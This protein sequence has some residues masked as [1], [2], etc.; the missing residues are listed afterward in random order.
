MSGYRR[1]YDRARVLFA[2]LSIKLF[3]KKFYPF[4][5]NLVINSRCNLKCAYCFGKYYD[6]KS[7]DLSF[8]SF[9]KIVDTL[10]AKKTIYILM[11]GGETLL[12]QE[13]GKMIQYLY[14]NKIVSA[15]V[16]N[17]QLPEKIKEL[18]ELELLDNVCF[19][20]DGNREGHDKIRGRGSFD[21][22]LKSIEEVKKYYSTP[23]RIL[24]SAHRFVANDIDFMVKFARDNNLEWSVNFM[25]CGNERI[26]GERIDFTDDEAKTYIKKAIE[27][28]KQKYPIFVTEKIFNYCLNWPASY[29][30]KYF[31]KE[32]LLKFNFKK[33]IECQYGNYEIVIDENGK[34]YPCQAMQPVFDALSIYDVGFD[35]AFEH[36]RVKPC[37]TCCIPTM[38]NTSA[39][40]NWDFGVIT[41]T[42]L[43]TFRNNKRKLF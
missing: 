20:L 15:I 14:N 26:G 36:L 28:K 24:T 27:Y 43:N 7:P 29:N 25:F 42:I 1:L 32:E 9:K 35:R 2:I 19:S 23:I 11:Q 22:V 12:H 21:K 34:I 31:S 17:G 33:H 37:V 10:A 39:M 5:T 6:R 3:K 38:I 41:E 4:Y 18:P 13:L 8:E 40:I 30:K 16:S